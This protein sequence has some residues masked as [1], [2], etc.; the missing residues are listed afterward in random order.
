MHNWRSEISSWSKGG[1]LWN[2]ER[3]GLTLVTGGHHMEYWRLILKLFLDKLPH[4]CIVA[5]APHPRAV[6]TLH[7]AAEAHPEAVVSPYR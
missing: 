7:G 5:T 1:L 3:L 6:E 4:F 2:N